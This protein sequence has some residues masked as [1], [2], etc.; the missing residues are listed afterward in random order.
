VSDFLADLKRRPEALLS[1][2][3]FVKT[4]MSEPA[5]VETI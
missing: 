2:L 1:K 5:E 4:Q 3:S